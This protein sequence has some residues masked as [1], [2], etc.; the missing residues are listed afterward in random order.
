[1]Q[2]IKQLDL[3][4]GETMRGIKLAGISGS[5]R[6]GATD[7]A[8]KKALNYAKE[9]YQVETDY[10]TVRGKTINFCLH[11]DYCVRKKEGCIQKDDVQQ[12][13]PKLEWANAW[14]LGSP[15]YQGQISGQ[16]KALLDR[17]RATVA[18]NLKVFENKVGAAIAVGGDRTGGQEQTLHTI[19]DFYLINE[20]IPVGGGSFGANFGGAV[21]SKDQGAKGAEADKEGLKTIHK[22]VDRLV[23]VAL[24][25]TR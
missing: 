15:V 5:P 17:C 18:K 9:K 22:T 23:K 16:L 6:V 3:K 12:I 21:W 1:M 14:I 19:I 20:M 24:L 7:Y 25:V 13:Y 10:V 2:V 8:V 11:C 4:F